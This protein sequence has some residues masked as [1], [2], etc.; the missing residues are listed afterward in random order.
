MRKEH[1]FAE[2]LSIILYIKNSTSK[3]AFCFKSE[4]GI[5]P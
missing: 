1:D 5:N 4:S 3:S 2:D